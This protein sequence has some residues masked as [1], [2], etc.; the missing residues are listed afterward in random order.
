MYYEI[1]FKWSSF[2]VK[3]HIFHEHPNKT[4]KNPDFQ[5]VILK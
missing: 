4:S 3:S 2:V 5:N 1:Y